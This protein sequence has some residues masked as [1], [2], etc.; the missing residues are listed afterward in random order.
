MTEFTNTRPTL[1]REQ[2]I[3]LFDKYLDRATE[4]LLYQFANQGLRR[5]VQRLAK[6]RL[7]ANLENFGSSGWERHPD[8][9]MLETLEELADAIC[10]LVM[11]EHG[12]SGGPGSR[13]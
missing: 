12:M 2:Q 10:Y 13:R 1:T 11:R 8:E 7:L 4:R 5:V 6:D 9:L 3:D